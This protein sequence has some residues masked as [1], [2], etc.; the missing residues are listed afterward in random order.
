MTASD[1]HRQHAVAIMSKHP[2]IDSHVDAP[3]VM[4]ALSQPHSLK[5]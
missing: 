3:F 4:R 1:E 5:Y 2:F